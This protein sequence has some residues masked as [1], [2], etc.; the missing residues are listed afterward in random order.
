MLWPSSLSL[1]ISDHG[2]HLEAVDRA[3]L[4]ASDLYI[5]ARHD[6]TLLGVGKNYECYIVVPENDSCMH[7]LQIIQ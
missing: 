7:T 4:K 6:C 1:A 2:H 3:G 5:A